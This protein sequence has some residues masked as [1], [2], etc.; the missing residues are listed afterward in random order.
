M[1][2]KI[3][4]KLPLEK[5]RTYWTNEVAINIVIDIKKKVIFYVIGE[6]WRGIMIAAMALNEPTT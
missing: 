1:I 4:K 6:R 5:L 3:N 2:D